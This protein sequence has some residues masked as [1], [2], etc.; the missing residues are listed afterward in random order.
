MLIAVFIV[1]GII[2]TAICIVA[3]TSKKYSHG[4]THSAVS[5]A[6][7]RELAH[8]HTSGHVR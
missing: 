5:D 6:L 1:V 8:R 3:Y 4:Q 7:K 2:L